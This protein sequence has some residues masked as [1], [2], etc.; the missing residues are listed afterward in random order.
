MAAAIGGG[1]G[2][3]AGVGVSSVALMPFNTANTFLGSAFFGYGMI[4]GERYMYQADWPKIQQRLENG[5]KIEN[6]IQE[7]TG[8]FTAVV[9]AEAKIIFNSVTQEMLSM[10]REAALSVIPKSPLDDIRPDAPTIGDPRRPRPPSTIPETPKPQPPPKIIGGVK[11]PPIEVPFTPKKP[12]DIISNIV[13]MNFTSSGFK[14]IHR[15]HLEAL[16]K[17]PTFKAQLLRAGV[18]FNNLS[19]GIR[20]LSSSQ[21]KQNVGIQFVNN[22]NEWLKIIKMLN[23]KITQQ[24]GIKV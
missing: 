10:M 19:A 24:T 11:L 14:Y 4:L 16:N 17:L 18:M 13:K 12:T 9:M 6:I 23:N 21:L 1:V 7:Y 3:G 5:E 2:I 15:L 8:R 20:K 22:R